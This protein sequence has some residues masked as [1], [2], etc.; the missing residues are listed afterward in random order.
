MSH[1]EH[2]IK[3]AITKVWNHFA[4]EYIMSTFLITMGFME[5]DAPLS[6]D[7]IPQ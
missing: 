4:L 5:F 3:Q 7:C 6:T 2:D 1:L